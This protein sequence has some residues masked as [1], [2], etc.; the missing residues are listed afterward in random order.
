MSVEHCLYT[1]MPVSLYATIMW[2][3]CLFIVCLGLSGMSSLT[4]N[5]IIPRRCARA[6]TRTH[7]SSYQNGG[8]QSVVPHEVVNAA[9]NIKEHN[10]L[11]KT[12]RET[13]QKYERI[14]LT[15]IEQQDKTLHGQHKCT[16][17]K[18]RVG[19]NS[20]EA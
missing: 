8:R 18:I 12:I 4:T 7:T 15:F 13:M 9:K 17:M 5:G 20:F 16:E 19:E 1:S 10:E 14:K 11:L 6:R 3:Y 2:V